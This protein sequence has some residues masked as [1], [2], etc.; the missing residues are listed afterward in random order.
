MIPDETILIQNPIAVTSKAARRRGQGVR[1]NY[2]WSTQAQTISADNGYRP[3]ISGVKVASKYPTPPR[4]FT[5]DTSAAG[6]R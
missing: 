2:L 1:S 5:I 6:I 4:L 3:V